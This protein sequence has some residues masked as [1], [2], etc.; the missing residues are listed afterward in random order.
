[1]FRFT[2]SRLQEKADAVFANVGTGTIS[3]ASKEHQELPVVARKDKLDGVT[4]DEKVE[5]RASKEL[6]GCST[7]QMLNELERDWQVDGVAMRRPFQA[8]GGASSASSASTSARSTASSS[9]GV[10]SSSSMGG[11]G[12]A[13]TAGV[14]TG[15]SGGRNTIMGTNMTS[16]QNFFLRAA[17]LLQQ[18][19][20]QQ[21]VVP[22]NTSTSR[23]GSSQQMTAAWT[24]GGGRPTTTNGAPP[25]AATAIT[26]LPPAPASS[27]SNTNKRTANHSMNQSL[28]SNSLLTVNPARQPSNANDQFYYDD[29]NSTAANDPGISPEQRTMIRQVSAMMRMTDD[30]ANNSSNSDR[31]S[32]LSDDSS[33]PGSSDEGHKDNRSGLRG[34]DQRGD[35]DLE[36]CNTKDPVK[37]S[38]LQKVTISSSS[39]ADL[40]KRVQEN[41]DSQM[42][43]SADK[44]S[45]GGVSDLHPEVMSSRTDD[46]KKCVNYTKFGHCTY[47]NTC[48]FQHDH[49]SEEHAE[50][51]RK[52]WRPDTLAGTSLSTSAENRLAAQN[53][54]ARLSNEHALAGEQ[55]RATSEV[56][57]G[58]KPTFNIRRGVGKDKEKESKQ[59]R[60]GGVTAA[61]T[62]VSCTT[63]M[64]VDEGSSSAPAPAVKT[65]KPLV[66][67]SLVLNEEDDEDEDADAMNVDSDNSGTS[68]L[69]IKPKPAAAS[70]GTAGST[71]TNKTTS[72]KKRGHTGVVARKVRKRSHEEEDDDP[73]NDSDDL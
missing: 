10:V 60:S 32:L 61:N 73:M 4:L 63:S 51:L 42:K 3:T 53:L 6:F 9:S 39:L 70:S 47:G 38:E 20:G 30:A 18:N 21:H 43:I 54:L 33:A 66:A 23:A 14:T 26:D 69:G 27:S 62:A 56:M 16:D 5:D 31:D 2:E 52:K 67:T 40:E 48:K 1:M 22:S 68:R 36:L 64:E 46:G 7:E 8:G 17:G 12:G 41:F 29:I 45:A 55:A 59:I 34:D 11:A 35:N 72:F 65:S 19:Q 28:Q 50:Q 13:R 15:S 58:A 25:S 71:T 24:L 37:E 49:V 57:A 44:T